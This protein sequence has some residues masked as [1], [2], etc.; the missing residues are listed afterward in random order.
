MRRGNL[1]P[2]RPAAVDELCEVRPYGAE[3]VV[4]RD[5]AQAE[6]RER[7]LQSD[8]FG[9]VH[10]GATARLGGEGGA[11]AVSVRPANARV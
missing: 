2:G 10:R 4:C 11:C 5:L 8:E 6:T 7:E 9:V 1:K 3:G